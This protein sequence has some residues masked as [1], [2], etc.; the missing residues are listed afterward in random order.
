MQI[1]LKFDSNNIKLIDFI[2]VS[3][4]KQSN[5]LADLFMH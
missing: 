4:V 5:Y 2:D 3:T 1:F